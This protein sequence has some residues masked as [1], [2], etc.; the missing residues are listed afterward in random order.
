MRIW[1]EE[2]N[3]DSQ[4][5]GSIITNKRK[6]NGIHRGNPTDYPGSGIRRLA[7]FPWVALLNYPDLPAVSIP[8]FEEPVCER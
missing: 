1:V 6:I 7:T 3:Q 4:G 2:I 8:G 5:K